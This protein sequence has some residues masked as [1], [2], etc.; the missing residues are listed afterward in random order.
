MSILI[1]HCFCYVASQPIKR[2]SFMRTFGDSMF[3]LV[4]GHVC[5][6]VMWIM[7]MMWVYIHIYTQ[8]VYMYQLQF[9]IFNSI[10]PS[11]W[12]WSILHSHTGEGDTS[13]MLCDMRAKKYVMWD[14]PLLC[15]PPPSIDTCFTD[16]MV[17][18]SFSSPDIGFLQF[19]PMGRMWGKSR[20]FKIL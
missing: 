17:K 14:M 13:Y 8:I 5:V 16:L 1:I 7:M 20:F 2:F 6:R 3:E 9:T 18:T 4:C 19:D 12:V 15:P 11:N 10:W